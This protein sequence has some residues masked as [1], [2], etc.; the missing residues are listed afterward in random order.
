MNLLSFL[1]PAVIV[2]LISLPLVKMFKG[3]LTKK[4]R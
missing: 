4:I 3:H 1:L 2:V